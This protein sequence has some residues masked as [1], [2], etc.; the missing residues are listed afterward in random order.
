MS[1]MDLDGQA[2]ERRDFPIA[3]R[4]YEPAAVD[5][6]LRELATAVQ[7]LQAQARKGSTVGE[8]AGTHVQGII[9]A[10]ESAAAKIVS[11]ARARA[12]A[13]LAA[14]QRDAAQTREDALAR[15]QAHTNAVGEA[16]AALR[17]RLGQ[18]EAQLRTLT[19]TLHDGGSELSAGVEQ[20]RGEMGRLYDAAAGRAGTRGEPAQPVAAADGDGRRDADADARQAIEAEQPFAAMLSLAAE[21]D[22][23]PEHGSSEDGSGDLGGGED[24][25]DGGG[26]QT[27]NGAGARSSDVDGAR[28]IALNMAL[29]G[30]SREQTDRYLAEH[31]DLADRAKLVDEVFAAID[32]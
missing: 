31:F 24:F 9:D 8:S 17:E 32:G 11:D 12:A 7:T 2:I 21:R 16:A 1:A 13:E 23:Q 20:L 15:A 14:A 19:S 4:G 30:D 10:A 18:M 3:R 5:A 6:H 27:G 26:A 22:E 28:L 25:A 29:N